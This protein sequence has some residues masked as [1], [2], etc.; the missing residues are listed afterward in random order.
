MISLTPVLIDYWQR[1]PG[2][3]PDFRRRSLEDVCRR[4]SA[5]ELPPESLIPFALGDND[6]DVVYAAVRAYIGVDDSRIPVPASAIE[7]A[8]QWVRRSLA[9]NRGAV[10][11]ALLSAGDPSINERLAAHRLTLT[12][13]EIAVVCRRA[14]GDE[15]KPT[16]DFLLGWI[17]L[18]AG[19]DDQPPEL[20]LISSSLSAA[21]VDG[22]F[23]VP[24][25]PAT[26]RGLRPSSQPNTIMCHDTRC[27]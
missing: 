9:L 13:D 4:V 22:F 25:Q 8:V 24:S 17:E 5:F 1:L 14:A 19:D 11:A 12:T 20:D 18:L 21:P 15:R 3:P 26:S 27:T 7:D 6:D 23:T 16:R 10:F 2:N